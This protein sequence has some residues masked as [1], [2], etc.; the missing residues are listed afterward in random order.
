MNRLFR[1]D[2]YEHMC[3]PA[4]VAVGGF[5]WGLSQGMDRSFFDRPLTQLINGSAEG[6]LYSVGAVIVGIILPD[7]L[8][9]IITLACSVATGRRIG[10]IIAYDG[11]VST[12]QAVIK[13]IDRDEST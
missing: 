12:S 2:L 11:H 3:Q 9:G 7:S 10:M 5:M 1:A 8:R 4:A 13:S 6:C